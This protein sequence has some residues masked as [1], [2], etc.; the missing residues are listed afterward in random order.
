[1]ATAEASAQEQA[2]TTDLPIRSGSDS[3][4]FD[5]VATYH[6]LLKSDPDLTKPVAAINALIALLNTVP[7]TTVYETLDIIKAHS[8]RLKASVEN[9]IPLAA[10]TD[11]FNQYIMSSLKQQDGSFDAARNGVAE[12][13]WRYVSEGST[14]LTHGASRSV[15]GLLARA[16]R[17]RPG[18]F[19]VVYV[20][21]EWRPKESD[22]VVGEL[23]QLG[24]PTAEI[25][26]ASVAH[27]MASLRKVSMVIVGAEVVTQ[28]GGIIS[29]MGSYQIAKLAKSSNIPFYVAGETHKFS[30]IFLHDQNK[31][32]F[33]QSVLDFKL[34][35]SSSHLENPVDFTPPD[36]ISQLITENG[37][38]LPSYV[39]E[40]ILDIYGSLNG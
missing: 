37:V 30:R 10:G 16:A 5:I 12:A 38:K 24:I 11:L 33:K 19:K 15:T 3:T 7:S 6:S 36:L 28:S 17:S 32:G 22:R 31:L 26:L 25:D 13:G 1:M 27:V 2:P 8:E 20:R 34:E 9:P 29:R 21:D 35:G 14:V 18:K 23:R 40:Q 39:V 4:D